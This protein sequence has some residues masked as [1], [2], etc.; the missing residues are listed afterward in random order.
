MTID[1]VSE[2]VASSVEI[3]NFMKVIA[4]VNPSRAGNGLMCVYIDETMADV[5]MAIIRMSSGIHK[6]RPITPQIKVT[7]TATKIVIQAINPS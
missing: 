5:K 4:I 2:G 3:E 1:F 6:M 7:I